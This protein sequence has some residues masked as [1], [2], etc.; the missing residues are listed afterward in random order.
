MFIYVS[1]NNLVVTCTGPFK[2]SNFGAA[3]ACGHL[4]VL[5]WTIYITLLD[6]N[7][8][9][10]DFL[11]LLQSGI[12][13]VRALLTQSCS[14]SYLNQLYMAST[15]N[16]SYF[17]FASFAFLPFSAFQTFVSIF[18]TSKKFLSILN[19]LLILLIQLSV[20]NIIG[21]V[22]R[23]LELQFHDINKE[24]EML[25]FQMTHRE[26]TSRTINSWGF[27]ESRNQEQGFSKLQRAKPRLV[28]RK[29]CSKLIRRLQNVFHRQ[30]M[31]TRFSKCKVCPTTFRET[32]RTFPKSDKAIRLLPWAVQAARIRQQ[33]QTKYQRNTSECFE[34][35]GTNLHNSYTSDYLQ[36]IRLAHAHLCD[37]ADCINCLYGP[38]ALITTTVNFCKLGLL[39]YNFI[40]DIIIQG[41][42]SALFIT[43]TAINLM[44]H[45]ARLQ[46][47]CYRCEKVCCEVSSGHTPQM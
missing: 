22:E 44:L 6:P 30:E 13:V 11:D 12:L 9:P 21:T 35:S 4:V 17:T 24:L 3:L 46:Y 43:A 5:I 20:E 42:G 16:Q 25:V 39:L 45:L 15:H 34:S 14:V 37:I 19:N 10:W 33:A 31:D 27:K 28:S 40:Q 18:T 1:S 41:A 8:N 23:V 26:S 47:I 2:G 29:L 38:E 7:T 32:I 36:E